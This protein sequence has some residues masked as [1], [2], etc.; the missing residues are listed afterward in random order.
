MK[1]LI[2]EANTGNTE[3][4][5]AR[6]QSTPLGLQLEMVLFESII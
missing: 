1:N 6:K 2:Y 3:R 5:G 4:K